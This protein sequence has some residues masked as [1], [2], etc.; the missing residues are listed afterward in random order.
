M[1]LSGIAALHKSF[2]TL[3]ISFIEKD[4][5]NAIPGVVILDLWQHWMRRAEHSIGIQRAVRIAFVIGAYVAQ[6]LDARC[7]RCQN[8]GLDRG[9][10]GCARTALGIQQNVFRIGSQCRQ[11]IPSQRRVEVG[12]DG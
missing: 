8:V 9:V 10:Q 7:L 4:P 5:V 6:H 2:N 3:I 1:D 11:T 12:R